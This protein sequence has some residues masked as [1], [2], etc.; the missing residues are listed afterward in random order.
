MENIYNKILQFS[1]VTPD[2]IA[3]RY[4]TDYLT[5]SE[6]SQKI[7]VMSN[8]LRKRHI[9]TKDIV[10][11]YM[12]NSIEM[13]IAILTL[14]SLKAIVLP[15]DID[16]PINRV[17]DTIND[18]KPKLILCDSKGSKQLKNINKNILLIHDCFFEKNNSFNY[19][20]S[21]YDKD[22]VIYCIYTS[23]STGK[24]K[25]ILLTIGGIMN[26]MKAKVDLLNITSESKLCLSFNI[27][28]V[29]SIWQIITPF[30][31]GATLFVYENLSLKNTL[32]FM[33]KISADEINVISVVP[34]FLRMYCELIQDKTRK[35]A[36]NKLQFI[37]LTGEKFNGD[38]VKLFYSEYENTILVNAYGQS[39]C[40]DD[41]FHYIIPHNYNDVLVP[42]GKSISNIDFFV[43][44][45]NLQVVPRN[46][47]GELFVSGVA[48]A[49]GYLNDPEKTNKSFFYCESCRAFVFRTGDIVRYTEQGELIYLGRADNQIKINGY[50]IEIEDIEAQMCTYFGISNALVHPIRLDSGDMMLEAF[51]TAE[52]EINKELMIKHL[53]SRV[54]KYMIPAR[55][56]WVSD[57]FYLQNG[58]I[59]RNNTDF[60]VLSSQAMDSISS[61]KIKGLSSVQRK[62]F[63]IIR[64]NLNDTLCDMTPDTDFSYICSDSIDFINIVVAL[65][66]EF[67]FD[68]DE[69]KLIPS[70]FPTIRSLT[71]Y[72]ESK[73]SES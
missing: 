18:S 36:F 22:D 57:F 51:Y 58:K 43:M 47:I 9:L 72:V 35:V 5:Y 14:I 70:A 4:G 12:D 24:P 45:N 28:F 3:L 21:E 41:I 50:R 66:D 1:N 61:N 19:D 38:I 63:D 26:H 29:A 67:N 17:V 52:F 27:S 6:L 59:N 60:V 68:F 44:D 32:K 23:G 71:T 15:I 46:E 48:L 8:T 20:Y 64:L 56:T 62:V 39:E 53:L 2:K 49:N 73:N 54:P 13:V 11:I 7:L 65:E 25:G 40:S 16:A 42:M 33:S 31:V 69:E 55:F 10:A 37:V 30:C 34:Q